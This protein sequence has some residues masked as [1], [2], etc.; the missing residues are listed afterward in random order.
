MLLGEVLAFCFAGEYGGLGETNAPRGQ[1]VG[2]VSDEEEVAA[3]KRVLLLCLRELD[4]ER[5]KAFPVCEVKNEH[6]RV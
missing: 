4:L 1:H 6:E 3:R 2:A 5:S